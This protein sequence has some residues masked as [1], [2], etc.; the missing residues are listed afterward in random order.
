MGADWSNR[1]VKNFHDTLA[2]H[3]L[4]HALSPSRP[5]SHR[6]VK[7]TDRSFAEDLSGAETLAIIEKQC[8]SNQ[9][10]VLSLFVPV[11]PPGPIQSSFK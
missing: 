11:S 8:P 2:V 1:R 5:V 3:T 4:G 7:S 6:T 9:Q 10:L